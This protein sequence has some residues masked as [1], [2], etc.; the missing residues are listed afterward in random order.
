MITQ[1][2]QRV[3][4]VFLKILGGIPPPGKYWQVKFLLVSMEKS[5]HWPFLA[6]NR[7]KMKQ[8][9]LSFHQFEK[10]ISHCGI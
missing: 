4:G 10:I 6:Q 2:F 5:C 8:P 1:D 7:R 9:A 3:K